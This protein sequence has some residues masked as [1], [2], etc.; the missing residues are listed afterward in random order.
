VT[1]LSMGYS[2]VTNNFKH[3]NKIPGVKVVNWLK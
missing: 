1:A 3:F 2:I